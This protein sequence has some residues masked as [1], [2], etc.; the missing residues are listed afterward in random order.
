MDSGRLPTHVRDH[1]VIAHARR[2][3]FIIVIWGK[4]VDLPELEE[5][6]KWALSILD[7]GRNAS[8]IRGHRSSDAW[9][10]DPDGGE[11]DS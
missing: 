1:P 8:Y 5:C 6:E 2:R 3:V 9:M 4:S 10:T 7:T 11:W